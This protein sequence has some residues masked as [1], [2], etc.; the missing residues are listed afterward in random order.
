MIRPAEEKDVS[1][2][3]TLLAELFAIENDFQIEPELQIK[4]LK[5]LLASRSA[6]VLVAETGSEVIAM[7]T[8]QILIS[9]AEGG[10]SLLV[11]DVVVT[12]EFKRNGIG[13]QLL[14][15][16]AAEAARQGISRLQLLADRN[17]ST[18]LNFYRNAGWD[19]TELIC[20]RYRV[21]KEIIV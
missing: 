15:A 17:N 2:M 1:A 9:T 11:E 7:C 20:L 14:E 18:A 6:I 16:I 5:L 3:V 4:G 10:P 8:G 19:S 13:K 21:P 12:R